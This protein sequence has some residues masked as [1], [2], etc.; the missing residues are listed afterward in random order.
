MTS[1]KQL[2]EKNYY[3]TFMEGNENE[4]PTKVLGEL[5]NM[6]QQKATADL[7]YLR[8]AQGEIYFLNKDYETAIFKWENVNNEL[9][10]WATK[11]IADAHVE[12][13]F[14]EIAVEY[15][16]SVKTDSADLKAEVLLQLFSIYKQR[17]KLEMAANSIKHAVELNPDYPNVTDMARGFF[18]EQSDFSNA[19]ELAASEAIRTESLLWFDVLESY[20][21]QDHTVGMEPSYFRE[22]LMT[23]YALNQARFESLLAAQW[24][25]YERNDS[26]LQWLKEIN[27]LLLEINP[28]PS[29]TWKKLTKLYNAKYDELMNGNLLI[30]DLSYY[31]PNH[32]TNWLKISIGSDALTAASA[33]LTWNEMYPVWFDEEIVSDAERLMSLPHLDVN[34]LEDVFNIFDSIRK[35]AKT[36]DLVLSEKEEWLNDELLDSNHFHLMITGTE[37]FGKSELVNKLLGREMSSE[38]T[39]ATVLFKHADQTE[40]QAITDQEIRSI[41]EQSELEQI[42]EA[43]QPLISYKM[44]LSFLN[45]NKLTLIDTPAINEEESKSALSTYLHLADSLLFVMDASSLLT[46]HEIELAIKIREQESELPIHFLLSDLQQNADNEVGSDSLEKTTSWIQTYFPSSSVFKRLQSLFNLWCK[47]TT[48]KT[49]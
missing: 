7:S 10:P 6:E 37:A 39:S 43:K 30:E 23:L 24:R 46:Y 29:H 32:L 25:S 4:D 19:V 14:L 13:D 44:P 3:Q 8:F 34:E 28:R 20:I 36:N 16:Q 1:E 18:E 45:N 41:T 42:V 12:L 15:Y 9:M 17:G 47:F 22:V 5:F 26:S 38:S 31:I 11:N 49:K 40:I 35:W 2:I 48:Q 21:E 33:L 27:H